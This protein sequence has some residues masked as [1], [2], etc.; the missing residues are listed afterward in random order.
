MAIFFCCK[1]LG[2]EDS[3]STF[4]VSKRLCEGYYLKISFY[5][6]KNFKF[7][8]PFHL[9]RIIDTHHCFQLNI[10]SGAQT[11][12]GIFLKHN[13]TMTNVRKSDFFEK[14]DLQLTIN[15]VGIG[16]EWLRYVLLGSDGVQRHSWKCLLVRMADTVPVYRDVH[17][18][19]SRRS[20]KPWNL[21]ILPNLGVCG[22]FFGRKPMLIVSLLVCAGIMIGQ[23]NSGTKSDA[24]GILIWDIC[25]QNYSLPK[26]TR[27]LPFAIRAARVL[28]S[29]AS[30]CVAPLLFSLISDRATPTTQRRDGASSRKSREKRHAAAREWQQNPGG[31][32]RTDKALV[33]LGREYHNVLRQG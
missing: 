6:S 10:L 25:F 9:C 5:A 7:V 3:L 26:W 30:G 29:L 21:M 11:I 12:Y 4:Y 2:I 15:W 31:A 22:D 27:L 28:L 19:N 14:V 24:P 17:W 23:G 13:G 8:I 16:L 1:L 33:G 32:K 20:S 18:V